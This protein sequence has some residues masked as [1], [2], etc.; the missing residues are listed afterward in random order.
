MN[1]YAPNPIGILNYNFIEFI[2]HFWESDMFTVL[3]FLSTNIMYLS[4]G[5]IFLFQLNF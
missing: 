5:F 1:S 3:H 4:K 2:D